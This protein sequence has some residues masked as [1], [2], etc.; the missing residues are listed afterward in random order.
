MPNASHCHKSRQ[1]SMLGYLYSSSNLSDTTVCN[2]AW[3]RIHTQ[4]SQCISIGINLIIK[5]PLIIII[6]IHNLLL[7]IATTGLPYL[8]RGERLQLGTAGPKQS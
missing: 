6:P 8:N 2:M 3:L 4:V 7:H 5:R 1:S